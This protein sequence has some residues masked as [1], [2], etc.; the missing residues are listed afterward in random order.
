MAVNLYA[1]AD[2]LY[3]PEFEGGEEALE[4]FISENL[5]YPQE[6]LDN[7]KEANVAILL[8]IDK[9][10]KITEIRPNRKYGFGFDEEALRLV[11]AMPTFKPA[12]R[13]DE[14]V[15]GFYRLFVSFRLPKEVRKG[16][17]FQSLPK[18]PGGLKAMRDFIIDNLEYPEAEKGSGKAGAVVVQ[19]TIDEEGKIVDR[20]FVQTLGQA[21]NIEVNQVLDLMPPFEPGMAGGEPSKM[22]YT[23]P[24][25]FTEDEGQKEGN[26]RKG[27]T[28]VLKKNGEIVAVASSTGGVVQLDSDQGKGRDFV[29]ATFPGG[30]NA[31][32]KYFDENLK[33]PKKARKKGKQ[34][35]VTA[36]FTVNK[37]G[38][39]KR[40]E[41]IQTRGYGMDDEVIRLLSNMPRWQP[42]TKAGKAVEDVVVLAVPFVLQEE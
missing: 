11:Q 6:A 26:Q 23:A 12:T 34:G 3:P 2:V 42:A 9:E 37:K 35:T 38:K 28:A 29:A 36:R 33:Y 14:A 20:R 7:N 18:Y 27:S 32:Q 22:F 24:F 19:L 1:Q 15:D 25:S 13:N 17:E 8:D 31:M 21:F 39:I 40:A 4:T 10:G 41:I 5:K 16:K 30:Y